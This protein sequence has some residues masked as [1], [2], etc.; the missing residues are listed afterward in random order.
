MALRYTTT[1][2]LNAYLGTSGI[3]ALL[4]QLGE[5]AEALLDTLM[6]DGIE[7]KTHTDIFPVGYYSANPC[8]EGRV[9]YLMGTNPTAVATVN[10]T[11]AGTINVD[12]TLRGTCLEFANGWT[13]PSAFPYQYK[14]AYTAG[15]STIP[16]DVQQAV[17]MI[18]GAL[19]NTRNANGIASFKQDLLS[20]NYKDGSVLDTIL[21]TE[22][23]GVVQAVVNR[24]KV[25]IVLS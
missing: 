17:N 3:D 14:I 25:H 1:A 23:K 13:S 7:S 11:S 21:D 19:Y 8:K 16:S 10:G 6:G 20:V 5:S 22:S 24:Y 12:Y 15:Y 9:F 2:S 18:V 4:T